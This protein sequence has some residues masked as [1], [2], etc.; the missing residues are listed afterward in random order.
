MMKSI[1]GATV[2]F[3][4]AS[5]V[6]MANDCVLEAEAP[7]MP[8]PKTATAEGEEAQE[9]APFTDPGFSP[10]FTQFESRDRLI[11]RKI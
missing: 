2:A 10:L 6:A 9:L 7:V 4:L 5:G 11:K 3:V 8:D 1:I